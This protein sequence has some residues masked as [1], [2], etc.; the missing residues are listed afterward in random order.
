[1]L[2]NPIHLFNEVGVSVMTEE[3]LLGRIENLSRENEDL[4]KRVQ[5]LSRKLEDRAENA[6]S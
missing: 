3:Y 4:K 6:Q 5:Y 1:M 2:V